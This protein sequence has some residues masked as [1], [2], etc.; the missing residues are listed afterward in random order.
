MFVY[1]LFV[2]VFVFVVSVGDGVFGRAEWLTV[3][4]G[5]LTRK[6]RPRLGVAVVVAVV[7]VVGVVGG[8][9]CSCACAG[10]NVPIVEGEERRG[11]SSMKSSTY[12]V[13]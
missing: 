10:A 12:V 6:L 2:F 1:V 4:V 13:L 7:V 11:R 9:G 5:A 8:Y 3:P